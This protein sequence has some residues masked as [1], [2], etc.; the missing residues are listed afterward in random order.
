[1]AV[2]FILRFALA[3]ILL[4]HSVPSIVTGDIVNFGRG[5]LDT[6]GFA[7][8]GIYIAFL[9]KGAHLISAPLLLM[10]RYLKA[11]SI[12]NILIFVAG[13]ILVHWQDGWYVVGGGRNGIE[14][15]FLL[16]ACFLTLLFPNGI[17]DS[18]RRL[19]STKE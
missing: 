8:W 17:I 15:N 1:M 13:I 14:F 11:I 10:N 4:A 3:I 7:P 9:V 5:Y 19:R 16:I 12:A 18:V 2:T 6:A